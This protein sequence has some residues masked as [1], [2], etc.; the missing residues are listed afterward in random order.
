VLA[1]GMTLLG[2]GM[3]L[4]ARGDGGGSWA[5][6]VLAPSLLCASGIGCS[7]ISTTISANSGV[8]REDS[9]LASGLVNSAFQ[10]GGSIGVAVLATIAAAGGFRPAFAAGGALALAG[11]A[12]AL[13]V[14]VRRP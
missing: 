10:V 13:A 4:F 7:F 11:A 9:G 1:T 5:A 14:L 3:L 2:A 6:G 8:A 12:V